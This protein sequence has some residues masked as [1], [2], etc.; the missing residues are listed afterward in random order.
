MSPPLTLEMAD[1]MALAGDAQRL[2]N[3]PGQIPPGALTGE[4]V[5][6]Q[7]GRGLNFDS[8]R[9]YQP[10]DD[11]R[12]IDWKAT[13]RLRSPWIRLYNEERERPVFILVDQRLDMYFGTRCQMKSVAAGYT[14]A[15]LAWRSWHDGD[16]L[17]CAVLGDDELALHP[18]RA[19][20]RNLM[21]IL[22]DIQR[23][24]ALLPDH[25]AQDRPSKISLA[26]ALQRIVTL[27]PSGSWLG[28]ISDFHDLDAHCDAV[29]AHL[30]RRCDI[31]AFV[32][33]DDLHRRLPAQGKLSAYYQQVS[34]VIP[35]SATLS[36]RINQRVTERLSL[37]QRRLQR[38]GVTVKTIVS[39]L[40]VLPQLQQEDAHA[41]KRF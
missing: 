40:P 29:L 21:P 17:G 1:L 6:R 5:S 27:L 19:P 35:L 16:R 12:L 28:I 3:P 15:L 13:A 39:G 4:R 33:L 11:V 25:Y 41:G 30:R 20:K 9:R 26:D 18:C 8:L 23:L 10:G 2:D 22:N 36:D 14:A 31:T 37:Q 38:V 24:N 34:S 32:T 7:Q